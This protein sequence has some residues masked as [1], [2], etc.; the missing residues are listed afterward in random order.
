MYYWRGELDDTNLD[1]FA[2][3]SEYLTMSK[4]LP[5]GV[6]GERTVAFGGIDVTGMQMNAVSI[7]LHPQIML[8]MN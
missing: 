2:D 5:E 4:P 1:G 8:V 3:E 6:A 7:T